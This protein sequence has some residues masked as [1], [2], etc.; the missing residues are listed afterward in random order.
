MQTVFLMALLLAAG[1]AAAADSVS[2]L[3][4]LSTV[5]RERL[6]GGATVVLPYRPDESNVDD[7][8]D[9]FVSVALLIEGR[10]KTIWEVIHDKENAEHFLDGVLESR[11]LERGENE[12]VV[13]QR[14][15]VGGPKGSYLY[16]LRHRLFPMKRSDFTFVEGEIRN[17]I[18]SWWIFDTDRNGTFLVVYSLHIDPGRFAPQFVVKRGMKKTMPETIMAIE[19]EVRKRET[20]SADQAAP[21]SKPAQTSEQKGTN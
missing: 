9:R 8:D 17:V 14:T 3:E 19:R 7:A 20:G 1:I 13:E 16:T 15:H 21:V 11:V 10:R 12:I 2:V 6:E 18:G 5:D 4:S